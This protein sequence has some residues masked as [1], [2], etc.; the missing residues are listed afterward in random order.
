MDKK[1]FFFLSLSQFTKFWLSLNKKSY[2]LPIEIEFDQN[3][4]LYYKKHLNKAQL[5]GSTSI[6]L[7]CFMI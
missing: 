3:S 4:F 2:H 7:V 1:V 5:E 6:K